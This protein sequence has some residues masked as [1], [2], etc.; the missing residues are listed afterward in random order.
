MASV[1]ASAAKM[2]PNRHPLRPYLRGARLWHHQSL[3]DSQPRLL[4]R[5]ARRPRAVK[6]GALVAVASRFPQGR[7][8][9]TYTGGG[10]GH[11]LKRAGAVFAG[12]LSGPKTRVLLAV[13]LGAGLSPAE[14][15]EGVESRGLQAGIGSLQTA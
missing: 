10:G 8:A 1:G 6:R 4:I 2:V 11:D 5:S 12:D 13:L 14:V 7:L 15:R 9:P 3:A